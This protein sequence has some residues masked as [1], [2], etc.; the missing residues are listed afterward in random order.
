MKVLQ[1]TSYTNEKLFNSEEIKQSDKDKE[2]IRKIL[3]QNDFKSIIYSIIKNFS[4]NLNGKLNTYRT[5]LDNCK[6]YCLDLNFMGNDLERYITNL[7]SSF[8][9][10]ILI[11]HYYEFILNISQDNFFNSDFLDLPLIYIRRF[12]ISLTK[13]ILQEPYIGYLIKMLNYVYMKDIKINEM[14]DS[15]V[16]LILVIREENKK[17]F[18]DFMASTKEILIN[19]APAILT[20]TNKSLLSS[21]S[22]ISFAISIGFL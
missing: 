12:F 21:P 15:I 10:V 19:P 22:L 20:F 18:I 7:K 2:F 8:K 3:N 6:Q 16:N 13:N 11:L 17:S 5:N 4:Q 9:D 14:T 1:R